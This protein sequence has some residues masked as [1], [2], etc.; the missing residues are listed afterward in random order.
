[1]ISGVV[2]TLNCEAADCRPLVAQ[3]SQHSCLEVGEL[4]DNRKLPVT[5]ES[6]G[7]KE[8][9]ELTRW[10]MSIPGVAF[11]DVIYVHFDDD[12]Q[13]PSNESNPDMSNTIERHSSTK[14]LE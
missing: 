9:E 11:V 14:Q 13:P 3:I 2:A 1:M 12:D 6:T 4:V 5:I 7:R 8:T 10:L